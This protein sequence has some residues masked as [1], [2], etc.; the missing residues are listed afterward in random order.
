MVA[1]ENNYHAWTAGQPTKSAKIR[2][3]ADH[4]VA[5]AEIAKF[6]NIRYQHARNVLVEYGLHKPKSQPRASGHEAAAAER[7][8]NIVSSEGGHG[9]VEIDESGTL[10]FPS[11]MLEAAG[12]EAGQSI[13]VS[14]TEDG[15]E[16]LSQD[17]ALRRARK[18]LR[19]YVPEGVSLSDELIA[20]RR[21]EAQREEE[22]L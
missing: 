2:V 6:L 11:E 5:T 4:G 10:K 12:L 14:L 9:W 20:E 7:E 1:M 22:G 21:R 16:L 3:L 18:I 19:K 13:L 17:A 15:L 8:A